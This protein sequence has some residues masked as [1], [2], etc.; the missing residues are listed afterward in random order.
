MAPLR[1]QLRDRVDR[2]RPPAARH[3][4]RERHARQLLRRR[5]VP[6][7]RRGHRTRTATGRAKGP[8]S[9]TSAANP[10]GPGPSRFRSTRNCAAC[11]PVVAELAKRT[12]VPDFRGHDEGRSR[13]A[14]ASKPARR[15]STTWPGFRD[16]AMIRVAA[17][18]RAGVIVM[19]MQGTP[20]T[21]QNDPHYTDVVA[22]GRRVL[23]GAV[24]GSGRIGYS[25]GGGVPRPRHRVRQDARPQP[26]TA[27]RTSGAFARFGRPV[28]LGVSRKGSSA[29]SDR[30]ASS[31]SGCPG[32]SPSRASPPPAAQAHV[33]R[34]HDVAPTRDAAVLLDAIDRHRR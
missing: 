23:R 21:M 2:V 19:H 13:P 7:R 16:P 25:T 18:H 6:R 34:V 8:T 29:S 24:A 33:L 14:R 22:R 9:S 27:R 30:P 32:R 11:L 10:P 1:W 31:A 20:Q 3:G 28:C 12:R 17:E 4:H 5:A 15:S 26:G